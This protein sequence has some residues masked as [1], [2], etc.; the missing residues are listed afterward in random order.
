MTLLAD[1]MVLGV[2]D[3]PIWGD[4]SS[5][6]SGL[7]IR[8]RV[9]APQGS[10]PSMIDPCQQPVPP[11]LRDVCCSWGPGAFEIDG[12]VLEILISARLPGPSSQLSAG[13]YN[14]G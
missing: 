5:L 12:A 4:V 13:L 9:H 8:L 7:R 1:L 2:A 6:Y 3:F 14:R 10:R 11:L